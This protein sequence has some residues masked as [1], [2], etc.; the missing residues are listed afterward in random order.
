V[1]GRNITQCLILPEVFDKTTYIKF[2]EPHSSSDGGALLLKAADQKLRL[3]S[4]IA[5]VL[6]DVRQAGKV[7]HTL[8]E[9]IQQRVYGLASGYADANDAARIGDDPVFKMLLDRSPIGEETL[10]SQATLS[11]FE[12]SFG[13]REMYRMG[14]TLA[15]AVLRR[16]RRRLKKHVK[17]VTID[18]DPTDDPTHGAQQMSFFNGHYDTYCYLPVLGFVSFNDEPD[19]YLVAAVLRPGNVKEK[20]GA[21]GILRR[22][23]ALIREKF[24]G[25]VIEV[26]L[27]GGF[28][29]PELFEYLDSEK[30]IE[31]VCAMAKNAVL[32]REAEALMGKVRTLS[33]KSGK[34]EHL[35]GECIYRAGTWKR[36]RRVIFKAEVV[37]NPGREAKDNPRFVVTNKKQGSRRLYKRNYCMRGEIENRIKELHHGMEI[38][39]TSC[40]K[41]WA[42]QFRVLMTAAAYALLQEIRLQAKD[43]SLG[44]AQVSTLREKLLK[45]SARVEES[46]RRIVI[47]LPETF[48]YKSEWTKIA[49]RMGATGG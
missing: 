40:T 7:K 37:R 11:R 19:Q 20:E 45:L 4:R 33:E 47:H 23:I 26:R 28:A 31:Y 16:H 10:S 17:R 34:T 1:S 30:Q 12:N 43:T 9:L 6:K 25:V 35:Y 46:V 15:E 24:S 5:S 27:D 14:E 18:L 48:A 42:N 13:P 22:L 29:C 38:D 39:R 41:F 44:R 21:I 36:E 49:K 3:T 32:E 8:L 2:D